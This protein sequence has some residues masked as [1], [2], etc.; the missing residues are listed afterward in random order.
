V[1]LLRGDFAAETRYESEPEVLLA[2]Y[3]SYGADWVHAVDLDGARDGSGGN[4]RVIAKLAAEPG[5]LLQV[6]G[7]LRELPALQE[8]LDLGAARA[9]VGSAALTDPDAVKGW[10]RHF[11]GARIALAFDVRLDA[12]GVPRVT[13]HGW[14]QQSTWSL[15]DAVAVFVDSGLVHVLCTDVSRDGALSGPNVNLYAEAARRYPKIAWQASGGIRDARDL[16]ALAG[17]GAA[18]AISG[19]AMLEA[20]IPIE[21]LKPFLPNA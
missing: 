10:L 4:R 20:R 1:R 16:H 2:Q 19:R 21:E 14:L 7:G 9:V 5:T 17:C 11:G 18:A 6:G 12:G 3:R 8:M 15:W 13:S